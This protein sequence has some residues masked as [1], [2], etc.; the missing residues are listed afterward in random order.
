[1]KSCDTVLE[2]KEMEIIL[3]LA[4]SGMN[5]TEASRR[6]FVH[7]NTIC[8]HI[9]KILQKTGLDPRD[10]YDL[11]KLVRMAGKN[12]NEGENMMDEYCRCR[13]CESYGESGSCENIYCSDKSDFIPD[14]NKIIRKAKETG[15][16]VSDIIA[17]MNLRD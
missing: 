16:S 10:F 4:E 7:R 9:R 17:L 2:E 1:M 5:P 13:F 15:L 14:S 12:T 11:G 6:I 3:A 8:Y